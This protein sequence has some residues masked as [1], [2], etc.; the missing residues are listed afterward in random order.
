M[1]EAR[2]RVK[3]EVTQEKRRDKNE[4][5]LSEWTSRSALRENEARR[6]QYEER[7]KKLSVSTLIGL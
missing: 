6:R 1:V 7:L 2:R 3:A 4:R 5:E